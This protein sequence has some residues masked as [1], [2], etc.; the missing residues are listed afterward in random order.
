MQHVHWQEHT[1]ICCCAFAGFPGGSPVCS[2]EVLGFPPVLWLAK[3][4]QPHHQ[5]KGALT[6]LNFAHCIAIKIHSSP[7]S[8]G[9][10]SSCLMVPGYCSRTFFVSTVVYCLRSPLWNSNS[11]AFMEPTEMMC[12]G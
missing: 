6:I 11:H 9:I 8:K 4:Q 12:S 7:A 5:F 1:L 3:G 10:S 2:G